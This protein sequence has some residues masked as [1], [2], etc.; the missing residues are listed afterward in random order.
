MKLTV[1]R[2]SGTVSLC[3]EETRNQHVIEGCLCVRCGAFQS[4]NSD[5]HLL[6]GDVGE[7]AFIGSR[8]E[9]YMLSFCRS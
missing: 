1:G 6:T 3:K 4:V 5:Y 2:R 9:K 7:Y 8:E